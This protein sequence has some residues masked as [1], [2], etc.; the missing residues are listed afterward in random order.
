MLFKITKPL[1]EGWLN[2]FA[3]YFFQPVI[4][5]ASI[6]LL[7]QLIINQIYR[8]LGFGVCFQDYISFP[9]NG[10]NFVLM[11]AWQICSFSNNSLQAS[12][13]VPGYGFWNSLDPTHFCAPFECT[14][15]RYIA[16]PF[17]DPV[18]DSSLINAFQSPLFAL[19]LPMLYN[20]FILVIL[21]YLMYKFNEVIPEI[22]KGISGSSSSGKG[23]GQTARESTGDIKKFSDGIQN[24]KAFQ[25]LKAAAISS[26]KKMLPSTLRNKL[27]DKLDAIKARKEKMDKMEEDYYQGMKVAKNWIKRI[28]GFKAASFLAKIV[29]PPMSLDLSLTKEAEKKAALEK[30]NQ[31]RQ[32]G[33][34]DAEYNNRMGQ[35]DEAHS[36]Q[37]EKDANKFG[38]GFTKTKE[39][40]V[41]AVQDNISNKMDAAGR[42]ITNVAR[43]GIGL[44]SQAAPTI[45]DD[46]RLNVSD[47]FRA[48]GRYAKDQIIGDSIFNRGSEHDDINTQLQRAGREAAI[49]RQQK[50]DKKAQPAT[51]TTTRTGMYGMLDRAL[52]TRK[53]IENDNLHHENIAIL[54][55]LNPNE[56]KEPLD[57]NDPKKV[58]ELIAEV[59]EERLHDMREM[60]EKIRRGE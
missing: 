10:T 44:E 29:I 20:A 42:S 25:A 57:L 43:R 15:N 35:R 13:A 56:K 16:L 14:A 59:P 8:I 9:I 23:L 50:A 39:S 28:P 24:T 1:F 36:K 18:A 52:D 49:R 31:P 48:A 22:G 32:S 53:S 5:F 58:N 37:A 47:A 54:R 41:G 51:P 17:L 12:I 30:L 7:G 27:N 45:K 4:V 6:A 34:S 3:N 2:Q 55:A 19:S 38:Y 21:A 33:E 40:I 11:K 46:N 26:A 60:M